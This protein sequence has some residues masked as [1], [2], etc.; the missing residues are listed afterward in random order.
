MVELSL[1]E[2]NIQK[3]KRLQFYK[4]KKDI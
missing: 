3:S 4:I 1:C 2:M